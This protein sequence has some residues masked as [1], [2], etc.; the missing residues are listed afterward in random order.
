MLC[1]RLAVHASRAVAEGCCG[2]LDRAS[3]LLLVGGGGGVAWTG[4]GGLLCVP[5]SCCKGGGRAPLGRSLGFRLGSSAVQHLYP[6]G[7]SA[8]GRQEPCEGDHEATQHG[9]QV[10]AQRDVTAGVGGN[11]RIPAE[12]HACHGWR[13]GGLELARGGDAEGRDARLRGARADVCGGRALAPGCAERL[14]AAGSGVGRA[15]AGLRG[16]DGRGWRPPL[17]CGLPEWR[18]GGGFVDGL[19]AGHRFSGACCRGM[20]ACRED[21]VVM[22]GWTDGSYAS[23]PL[24]H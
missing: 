23:R 21:G 9:P 20:R 16:E 4:L 18:R 7:A 6:R 15:S 3:D 2:R 17:G 24:A 19:G 5:A 22:G 12:L 8:E 10:Q 13:R 1:Q 14:G 11:E